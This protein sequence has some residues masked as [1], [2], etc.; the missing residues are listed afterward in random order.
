M[1][2]L[3]TTFRLRHAGRPNEGMMAMP[4]SAS[5][6]AIW[7]SRSFATPPFGHCTPDFASYLS[8]CCWCGL[9][10]DSEISVRRIPGLEVSSGETRRKP[11][12]DLHAVADHDIDS[13]ITY[14]STRA[15]TAKTS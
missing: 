4:S 13:H 15:I 6:N 2:R 14:A 3:M 12:P 10:D 1:S 7:V 9:V 8:I 11:S 5:T